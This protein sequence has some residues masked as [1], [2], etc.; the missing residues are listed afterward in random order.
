MT[1]IP[2]WAIIATFTNSV[3]ICLILRWEI[4]VCGL[5]CLLWSISLYL[6]DFCPRL[7][8]CLMNASGHA[9]HVM[10]CQ[11]AFSWCLMNKIGQAIHVMSRCF[12]LVL[13][14]Y[15]VLY[16]L[17]YQLISQNH[18]LHSKFMSCSLFVRTCKSQ[19]FLSS[20]T[21]GP[22]D[23]GVLIWFAYNKNRKFV[24]FPSPNRSSRTGHRTPVWKHRLIEQKN[25]VPTMAFVLNMD[26]PHGKSVLAKIQTRYS[27]HLALDWHQV[28]LYS[29]ILRRLQDLG[30]LRE[31]EV[32]HTVSS[33]S[34]S[35]ACSDDVAN[36]CVRPR[37]KG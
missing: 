31:K 33:I 3:D 19:L 20:S 1:K 16:H 11:P 15:N 24:F 17:T 32:V 25:R 29:S 23:R 13:C 30:A 36:I 4:G 8:L 9:A 27:D 22:S 2:V 10:S 12:V 26:T 18:L 5:Y 7:I 34:A 35:V 28:W 6:V 14:G 21:T 37:S